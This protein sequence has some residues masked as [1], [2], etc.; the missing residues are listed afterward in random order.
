MRRSV[1]CSI[2][3]F[4]LIAA[5][6]PEGYAQIPN[7]GFES[8]TAG[9][10][11]LWLT[12][13]TILWVPVTQTI[14][15]RS[16][17]SAVAGTAVLYDTFVVRPL[18]TA[19]TSGTG[20]PVSTRPA[21]LHGWY[22]F[23]PVGADN[24]VISVAL[25]KARSGVGAGAATFA[26]AQTAFTEFVANIHYATADVPDS[27]LITISI[28]GSGTQPGS[29]FVMDDLAF[30]AATTSVEAA[31]SVVPRVYELSQNFP[32]P[33]N[34]STLIQYAIPRSGRVRLT[35]F[36]ILGREIATL[37]DAEQAAGTYRVRFD[38]S[39]LSSGSYFYRLQAGEYTQTRK[40]S[41][42]R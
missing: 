14:N 39:S 32:N 15:A 26:A 19:G 24:L 28:T 20:F 2:L 18:I 10:P 29:L 6:S 21:A 9:N 23:V 5:A 34:P 8:W 7:S 4:L 17:S 37:V 35:V 30:G 11:D 42:I 27:C 16:G 40:F 3:G 13:N 36:D 41:M 1:L 12:N 25:T 22:K 38:G 33:F 31:G